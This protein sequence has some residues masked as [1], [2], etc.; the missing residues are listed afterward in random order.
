MDVRSGWSLIF[1]QHH[2]DERENDE[3]ESIVIRKGERGERKG[4]RVTKEEEV[5][6]KKLI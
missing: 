4:G 6:R 2:V 3:G 5:E 1:H